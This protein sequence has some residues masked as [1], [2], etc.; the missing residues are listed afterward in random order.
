MGILGYEPLETQLENECMASP[1]GPR[2]VSTE[3]AVIA[4]VTPAG[5]AARAGL[6][7]GDALLSINGEPVR[8]AID[9]MFHAAEPSLQIY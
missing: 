3:S 8:D 5:P 4:E 2:R 1:E 6:S 9:L 7:P